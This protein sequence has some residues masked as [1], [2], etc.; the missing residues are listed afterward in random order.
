MWGTA[1]R[2][3]QTRKRCKIET[4]MNLR[5][6]FSEK[7]KGKLGFGPFCIRQPFAGTFK[8]M[9]NQFNCEWDWW[10]SN[11]KKGNNEPFVIK[12]NDDDESGS[13]FAA[14]RLKPRR[15][16]NLNSRSHLLRS[17][18]GS[19]CAAC[20]SPLFPFIYIAQPSRFTNPTF[21]K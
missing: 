2:D 5:N 15:A 20:G 9:G 12:T 6:N 14:T 19:M 18:T 13:R 3:W 10:G 8:K 4:V 7:R 17:R 16:L 21:F 1:I 11:I